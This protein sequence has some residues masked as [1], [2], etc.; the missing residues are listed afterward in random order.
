MRRKFFSCR[1][2]CLNLP[3]SLL[4]LLLFFT[5]ASRVSSPGLFPPRSHQ[6][7]VR[8][9]EKLPKQVGRSELASF[10]CDKSPVPRSPFPLDAE[11]RRKVK[12]RLP[13]KRAPGRGLG[14][15]TVSLKFVPSSSI[16]FIR[17]KAIY[18]RT[19]RNFSFV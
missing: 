4:S 15:Y 11:T 10:S 12:L 7:P 9:H 16:F 19:H 18:A 8:V 5:I 6:L 3:H 13:Q 1:I 2:F 14:N 17:T